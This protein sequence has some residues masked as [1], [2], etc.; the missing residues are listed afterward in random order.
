[1]ESFRY[2][3]DKITSEL[4]LPNFDIYLDGGIRTGADIFKACALGAKAVLIG[5]P[6]L[7]GLAVAGRQGVFD[8]LSILRDE[9]A[10][11]MLLSGCTTVGE[12]SRKCIDVKYL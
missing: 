8:V 6:V 3:L 11:S 9:F 10:Q 7:Y 1:M 2:S 4:T 5:R 12:I